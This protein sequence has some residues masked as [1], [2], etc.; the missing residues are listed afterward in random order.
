MTA[1]RAWLFLLN[2]VFLNPGPTA[3][4]STSWTDVRPLSP[5]CQFLHLAD[6]SLTPKVKPNRG[7]QGGMGACTDEVLRCRLPN[8]ASRW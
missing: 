4:L 2:P 8:L 6:A 3:Y 1:N 7:P 5:A